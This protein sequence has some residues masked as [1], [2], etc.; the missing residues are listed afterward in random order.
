MMQNMLRAKAHWT[1]NN[2][3][4][5]PQIK[6]LGIYQLFPVDKVY[7]KDILPCFFS[8]RRHLVDDVCGP[9]LGQMSTKSAIIKRVCIGEF[10]QQPM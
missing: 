10:G 5:I 9:Q 2:S 4:S 8:C 1:P 3:E 7:G 6:G